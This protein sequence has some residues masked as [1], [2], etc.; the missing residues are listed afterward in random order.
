MQNK[1]DSCR[2]FFGIGL[3]E[4]AKQMELE[5]IIFGIGLREHATQTGLEYIIF[6]DRVRGTCKTRGISVGYFL[7]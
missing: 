2:L 3:G 6:W 4:H 5:Y 1:G 7:G